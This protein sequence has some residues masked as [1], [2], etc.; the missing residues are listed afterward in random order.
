MKRAAFSYPTIS[1]ALGFSSCLS[2][3]AE[4]QT[5]HTFRLADG[6][7]PPA[8]T[9]ADTAMLVGSWE[10]SASPPIL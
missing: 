5:A 8:A 4:P 6:D 10:R 9:L 1:L 3:A 7:A 2:L